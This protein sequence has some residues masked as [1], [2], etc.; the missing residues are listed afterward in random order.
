MNTNRINKP[1]IFYRAGYKAQLAEEY[2]IMTGIRG[3]T[4]RHEFFEIEET[5]LMTIR[6][7][8]CWDFATKALDTRNF[9]RGSLV[10]DVG[11]QA[12][13]EG[14]LP[15]EAKEAV[16][17]ELVKICREDGMSKF[18]CWYVHKAVSRFSCRDLGAHKL[19]SAPNPDAVNYETLG[20]A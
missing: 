6:R 17:K 8:Y 16:D 7:G 5:G 10:H 15:W 9:L 13:K 12:I 4:V 18:R 3:W 2:S 20:G 11:C 14:I 1:N 19:Q